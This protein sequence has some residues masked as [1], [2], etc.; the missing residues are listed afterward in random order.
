M[1][2]RTIRIS[3]AILR[4]DGQVAKGVLCA[5]EGLS[6]NQAMAYLEHSPTRVVLEEMNGCR[7]RVAKVRLVEC[8]GEDE[9]Q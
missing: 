3:W 4:E 7:L 2:D 8:G 9:A 6:E 5:M 1:N